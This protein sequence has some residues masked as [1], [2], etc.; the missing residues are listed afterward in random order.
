[1]LG[2][3]T[4]I[5]PLALKLY[6]SILYVPWPLGYSYRIDLPY[7]ELKKNFHTVLSHGMLKNKMYS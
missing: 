5:F 1:M 4:L 6:D 3:K 2:Q 7:E